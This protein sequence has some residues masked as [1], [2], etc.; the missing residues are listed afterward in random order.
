MS[1]NQETGGGT[2]LS[3]FEEDR[4]NLDD[5]TV[6]QDVK[7][8]DL[9][10]E[11][12]R[13]AESN[14]V[15]DQL[16]VMGSVQMGS[17][18]EVDHSIATSID[19]ETEKTT[20]DTEK[21][22]SSAKTENVLQGNEPAVASGADSAVV[23]IETAQ[24]AVAGGDVRAAIV[25]GTDSPDLVAS[26]AGPET[27]AVVESALPA[28]VVAPVVV[29]TT[30]STAEPT[31]E[32]P[33]LESPAEAIPDDVVTGPDLDPVVQTPQVT[34]P[35][36]ADGATI[37][38]S[39]AVGREDTP[40]ALQIEVVQA[41]ADESLTVYIEGVPTGATLSAGEDLG[42]GVWSL[43]G[44][45]LVDLTLTPAADSD[46]DF[47]L[48]VRTVTTELSTGETSTTT[49]TLNVE[50]QAVADAP[51]LVLSDASGTEDQA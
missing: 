34:V 10:A 24:V 11:E 20:D 36:E 12:N 30:E 2:D 43:R 8:V 35:E 4:Q 6:L 17:R 31:P 19:L 32:S 29:V 25:D 45:D 37:A 5:M 42:D 49:Q 48:V 46:V 47:A 7:S 22:D 3:G 40:I 21:V 44:E 14:Q 26:V 16:V 33:T 50:V 41:D 18:M 27:P 51:T 15:T 39:D 13:N 23:P 9:S 28:A 1:E 38:S